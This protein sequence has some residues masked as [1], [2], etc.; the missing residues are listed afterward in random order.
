[1]EHL[2]APEHF[3]ITPGGY[4]ARVE[5]TRR[6]VSTVGIP[7]H[8]GTSQQRRYNPPVLI[9]S[10]S[11]VNAGGV[12]SI[13]FPSSYVI[14]NVF[15]N[16][17]QGFF[18]ADDVIIK[19]RL[20][21][22]ITK[23]SGSNAFGAYGFELPDDRT[24]G[25]GPQ[26]GGGGVGHGRDVPPERLYVWYLMRNPHNPVQMIRHHH[27][28]IQFDVGANLRCLLPFFHHNFANGRQMYFTGHNFAKGMRMIMRANGD[29]IHPRARI[30]PSPQPR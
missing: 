5:T 26:T 27:P 12:I 19:S 1:M 29:E 8:V 20:P 3:Q 24:E 2:C 18:I 15:A 16:F 14:D 21:G 9:I 30:I 23:P 17:M 28:R 4:A 6:V 25:V 13:L 7:Q 22:K 11:H 10:K